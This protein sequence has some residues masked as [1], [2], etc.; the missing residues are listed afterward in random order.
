MLSEV[1]NVKHSTPG[2]TSMYEMILFF[3]HWREDF[4]SQKMLNA[5]LSKAE[6][7]LNKEYFYLQ[8][9][10]NE[11]KRSK[12]CLDNDDQYK[13]LYKKRFPMNSRNIDLS[14][15]NFARLNPEE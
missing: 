10:Y 1:N 12:N 9:A 8:D 11:G 3:H 14:D 2:T 13:D 5:F 7:L 15:Y 6:S 4:K